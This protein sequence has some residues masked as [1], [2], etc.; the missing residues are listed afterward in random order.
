MQ[1]FQL[2]C[3]LSIA[4][5]RS[6][7]EASYQLSISQSSLS[8]HI[9]K[10]EDEFQVQLF[11]RSKRQLALTSAGEDFLIYAKNAFS[12]YQAIRSR[13]LEY[14][15][16]GAIRIGSVDHMGKVGLTTP[17]AQF[18]EKFPEGSIQIDIK[19]SQSTQV[20][21]WLLLGNT[22]IAFTAHIKDPVSGVSN[23]DAYDLSD[24]Y[25]N[26]LLRDEYHAI[27][28]ASH[29]LASREEIRWEDLA[30][31]KLVIL[32]KSNSV[33][34]LIRNAFLSRNMNPHIVFECNQVD[35]LL[36]M[37]A[38]G[39]G[40]SFLSSRIASTSYNIKR[41]RIQDSL[42]RDTCMIVPRESMQ[43]HK[44]IYRFVRYI[45]SWYESQGENTV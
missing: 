20:I 33:N 7:T 16:G 43:R 40:I 15:S 3:F 35:A 4:E 19:K 25:I 10:L 27:V 36:G 18:M 6:F 45:E 42:T 21:E 2:Q 23:F 17:I 11:D 5:C 34:A 22:D 29:P 1:I 24:Y 31:E 41:V 44:L 28:P 26:T 8:K 14:N 30:D 12:E 13:L 38:S 32:D 37:A 39:F 9:S